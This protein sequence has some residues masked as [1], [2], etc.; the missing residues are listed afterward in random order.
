MILAAADLFGAWMV[1]ISAR[2]GVEDGLGAA[3]WTVVAVV[4]VLC[5]AATVLTWQIARRVW[6]RHAGR[7]AKRL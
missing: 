5:I 7:P 4:G 3:W 1:E 2:A 6:P